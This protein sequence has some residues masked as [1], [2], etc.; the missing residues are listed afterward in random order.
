MPDFSKLRWRIA[1]GLK[2]LVAVLAAPPEI[3][4]IFAEAETRVR[5]AVAKLDRESPGWRTRTFD[6][7]DSLHGIFGFAEQIASERGKLDELKQ[8]LAKILKDAKGGS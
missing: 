2:V 8:W 3:R 6:G 4:Q 1:V 5:E 7:P